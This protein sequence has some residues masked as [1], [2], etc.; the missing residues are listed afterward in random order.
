MMSDS[1]DFSSLD[2]SSDDD[3]FIRDVAEMNRIMEDYFQRLPPEPEDTTQRL[4]YWFFY[5]IQYSIYTMLHNG[6]KALPA[7]TDSVAKLHEKAHVLHMYDAHVKFTPAI[8]IARKEYCT[9]I[10]R[11][12]RALP[13]MDAKHP[14][15]D[16][17][18]DLEKHK[19]LHTRRIKENPTMR[20]TRGAIGE[21]P[22]VVHNL[23]TGEAF[24]Y[25]NPAHKTWR[26][27]IINPLP[28]DSDYR[29]LDPA[30]I[31]ANAKIDALSMESE[32][33]IREHVTGAELNAMLTMDRL[34]KMY[35]VL[36]TNEWDKLLR[37]IHTMIHFEDYIQ[38]YIVGAITDADWQVI[39]TD[40][41]KNDWQAVWRF[42]TTDAFYDKPIGKYGKVK[43][44][45]PQIVTR[46]SEVRDLLKEVMG[47]LED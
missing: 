4:L 30:E 13:G 17:L 43:K 26:M 31:V 20:R 29:V 41:Y 12:I 34:G 38:N 8:D 47:T 3:A 22:E 11:K 46:I 45:M 6:E 40:E 18:N 35:C 33:A 5:H 36:V 24:D 39:D 2:S 23:I 19:E 25:A 42:L 10:N 1:E 27:L 14:I 16:F 37:V 28:S 9:L 21:R 7:Q 44:E 15:F 32:E